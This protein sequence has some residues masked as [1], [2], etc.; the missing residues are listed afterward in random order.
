MEQWKQS[1]PI[2]QTIDFVFVVPLSSRNFDLRDE[3]DVMD[4]S[5][6]LPFAR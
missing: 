1:V 5:D 2:L 3:F 4:A 6:G